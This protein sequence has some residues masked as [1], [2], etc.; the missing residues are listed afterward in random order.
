MARSRAVEKLVAA[1]DDSLAGIETAPSLGPPAR[2]GA[3]ATQDGAAASGGSLHARMAS[4]VR[5]RR[6]LQ[7]VS[8]PIGTLEWR[9]APKIVRADDASDR[10]GLGVRRRRT[11][12]PV[13]I[14]SEPRWRSSILSLQNAPRWSWVDLGWG[15]LR[16]RCAR[17]KG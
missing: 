14:A 17:G 9:S 7:R 13:A 12:K 3:S 10:R 2:G 1:S 4:A 15:S 6:P 8:L 5:D 16:E 11:G